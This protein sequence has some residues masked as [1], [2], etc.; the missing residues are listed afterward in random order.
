MNAT[1]IPVQSTA[2]ASVGYDG[3]TLTVEFHT[4]RSYDHPNVPASVFRALMSA[5]SK[6]TYYNR[7]IRDRYK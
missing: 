6:G 2:I 4:G 3:K 7:N 1:M 5:S